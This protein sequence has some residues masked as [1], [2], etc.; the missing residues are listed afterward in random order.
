MTV[1]AGNYQRA[2]EIQQMCN[3][4]NVA[5]S[6][7][8]VACTLELMIR[9]KNLDEVAKAAEQMAKLY[10]SFRLDEHKIID[11]AAL[12]VESGKVQQA[13]ELLRKRA[14]TNSVRGGTGIQKNIWQLLANMAAVAGAD[15]PDNPTNQTK[16][17]LE[18]LCELGYCDKQNNALLG[19]IIR[20]HLLKGEIKEAIREF[21][22]IAKVYRKTPLQ[23]ELLSTLIRISNSSETAVPTTDTD[24]TE[25]K[26]LLQEVMQ[27]T[28]SIHGPINANVSLVVAFAQSGTEN[29]LRKILIDPNVQVNM[30][31]ILKQC[32]Y[33]C[34]GGSVE[35][36][37]MLAKCSRGLSGSVREQDFYNLILSY[38]VRQN[39][40]MAALGLF[41]R[42]AA[43][44]EFK[45][46]AEFTRNLIGLLEK[47]NLEV[48]SNVKMMARN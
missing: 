12:L 1:R 19:P 41:D 21:N 38:Y 11:W 15:Q 35:P 26:S 45:L 2:L 9:T 5:L 39:D 8:M 29:Q 14:T 47:N 25:A 34:N 48:P 6:P 33:L 20:E 7:G 27:T 4:K 46:T 10:P 17:L 23:F 40:F 36:L 37:L 42:I 31:A 16:E 22:N 43:D 28:S 24:K 30:D 18:L 3:E 13:K 44:D 32:E